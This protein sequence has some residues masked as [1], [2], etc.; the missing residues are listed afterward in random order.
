[1]NT[2]TRSVE[3]TLTDVQHEF[4]DWECWRGHGRYYARPE[5]Y[6][7]AEVRGE[8]ALDLRD[9]IIKWLRIHDQI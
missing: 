2:W 7:R 6:P 9:E 1:M 4:A 5:G 8:D 3:P